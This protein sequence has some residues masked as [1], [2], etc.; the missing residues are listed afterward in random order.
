MSTKMKPTEQ[1]NTCYFIDVETNIGR[2]RFNSVPQ[3]EAVS[4]G[5]VSVTG[6]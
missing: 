6:T 5:I 1:K 2:S 4:I 3:I